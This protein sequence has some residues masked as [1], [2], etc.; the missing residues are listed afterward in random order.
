MLLDARQ[1]E[2]LFKVHGAVDKSG[3]RS[4]IRFLGNGIVLDLT[5]VRTFGGVARFYMGPNGRPVERGSTDQP[6][7]KR[8]P[9]RLP[10]GSS[11][12][13]MWNLEMVK[14]L[15]K[16]V[17]AFIVSKPSMSNVGLVMP[18][19]LLYCKGV[20]WSAVHVLEE[21]RLLLAFQ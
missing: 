12:R 1:F 20:L 4:K 19:Q 18:Y 9:F 16:G 14:R 10:E 17:A 3:G 6:V 15:P 7:T 13:F 21:L 8:D 11:Y 2:P 5:D